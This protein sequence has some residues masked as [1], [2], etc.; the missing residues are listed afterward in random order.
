[1]LEYLKKTFDYCLKLKQAGYM[2]QYHLLMTNEGR[3]QDDCK[4]YTLYELV[5]ADGLVA[6]VF[7]K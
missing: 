4:L 7:K 2:T 6:W 5:M 1:V 3:N